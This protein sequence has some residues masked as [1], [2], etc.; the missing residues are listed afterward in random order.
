M[1]TKNIFKTLAFAMLMPVIMFTTACSSDDDINNETNNKKGY[2]LPVTVNVTRQGDATRAEYNE[3]TK[4]LSFSTG[5]KLFVKGEQYGGA[6]E[7]AG[8]LDWESEGTFSGTIYTENQYYGTAQALLASAYNAT[9]LPADYESYGFLT[10]TNEGKYSAE[11]D[12]ATLKPDPN[13]AD[14]FSSSTK[15]EAVEQFS[16]EY[17]WSYN[18]GFAL[19]PHNAIVCITITGCPQNDPGKVSIQFSAPMGWFCDDVDVDGSGNATITVAFPVGYTNTENCYLYVNDDEIELPKNKNFEAGHIYNI[20][21]SYSIPSSVINAK[22]SVSSTKRVYFSKGNLQYWARYNIWR[23][24]EHQWDIV[25]DA[26]NKAISSTFDGYIDLFG[27]GTSGHSFTSGYG[28][29][30]QPWS[31]SNVDTHYGPTDGTSG[32][33]GTYTQG[34]WGTNIGPG[35]RTL[36]KDEWTYLFKTRTVNGGTGNDHSYTIGQSLNGILGIVIYPDNYTGSTYTSYSNWA[37][38]ESAGCVFLP[39]SGN[40]SCLGNTWMYLCTGANGIYWSSTPYDA[41]KAYRVDFWS[42]G[43]TTS[44]YDGRHQGCSVRLVFNE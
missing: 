29:A 4:K 36:T 40:R 31:T 20:T 28:S 41:E 44:E 14:L 10:I 37:T 23:F 35:W 30:Y 43:I 7:F 9:L 17:A 42:T 39:A 18:N 8:T 24:A 3:T 38:F 1:K 22:F 12:A 5:D 2:A 27:W 11:V 15:A 21:R 33:T 16:H 26:N 25:G 6:G 32:L 34:D 13:T 19:T